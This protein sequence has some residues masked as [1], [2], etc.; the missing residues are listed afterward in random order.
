VKLTWPLALLVA[1]HALVH[2]DDLY[3]ERFSPSP[4]CSFFGECWCFLGLLGSGFVIVAAVQQDS[5]PGVCQDWLVRPIRR[6]D[7]VLAKLLF[8]CVDGATPNFSVGLTAALVSGSSPLSSLYAAFQRSLLQMLVINIP[9]LA[10]ASITRNLLEVVSGGVALALGLAMMDGL[11][12]ASSW[13]EPVRGTG[14]RWIIDSAGYIVLILGA[15]AVLAVQIRPPPHCHLPGVDCWRRSFVPINGAD[16]LA[17]GVCCPKID[18]E[19]AGI[20]SSRGPGF[21]SGGR[22]VRPTA[23]RNSII[24]R[25]RARGA[26]QVYLPFRINRT[27]AR[28]RSS[29]RSS[30]SSADRNKWTHGTGRP[31]WMEHQ[32]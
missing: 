16:A 5:V 29:R 21:R 11:T 28:L 27:A 14:L 32:A 10:L 23:G 17:S 26:V 22:K 8:C 25:P 20:E 19:R 13:L 9:F 31:R 4:V 1:E 7:L 6:R 3:D 30:R 24:G 2:S 12:S 15:V 18:G